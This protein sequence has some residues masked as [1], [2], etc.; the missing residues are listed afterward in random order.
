MKLGTNCRDVH[1]LTSEGMDR[2]LNPAERLRVRLHLL[3]CRACRRFDAQMRLLRA[4]MRQMTP[5]GRD[6]EER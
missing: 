2:P 3:R 6:E 5:G 4:S 1:R